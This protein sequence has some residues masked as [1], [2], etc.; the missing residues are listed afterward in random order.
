MIFTIVTLFPTFFSGI[1]SDSMMK[2]AQEKSA[3]EV[4][5]IDIRDFGV[6][7]H[8]TVD[9]RPYGGGKGMILKVDV[10]DRAIEAARIKKCKKEIVILLD[11]RGIK[12][13]QAIAH[14]LVSYDHIILIAGHYEGYDERVRKFVDMEISLGDFVLTG[15]EIPA[16]AI[17]DSVTRLIKGAILEQEV[18][19]KESFSISDESGGILLEHPHYTRPEA[20]KG[21]SV[22]DILLSGDHKQ[23]DQFRGKKSIE[24]TK[25]HRPD[26]LKS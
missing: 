2:I 22:P 23:I 26:L 8:K 21:E 24:I 16:M 11:P 10:L 19:E 7:T 15:G 9:D 5:F 17:V 1:L 12:Y 25:K 14:N 3:I 4:K 13:T 6:G 18:V 20:Y